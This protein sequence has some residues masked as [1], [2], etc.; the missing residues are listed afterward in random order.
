MKLKQREKDMISYTSKENFSKFFKIVSNKK[1]KILFKIIKITIV[2]LIGI[3]IGLLISKFFGTLDNPSRTL[4]NFLQI[5]GLREKKFVVDGILAE[6]IKIPFNWLRSQFSRP[7]KLYIDIGFEEYQKIAYKRE[8]AL[9]QGALLTSPEDYVPATITHNGKKYDIKLRLKGDNLDHLDT[10]KWSFRINFKKDESLFGMKVFSIQHPKT[11]IYINE[12]VYQLM[13]KREGVISLR[14]DFVDVFINGKYKGIYFL[15]EHFTNELIT[16]NNLREGLIVKFNE[17]LVWEE[18]V[19]RDK[20]LSNPFDDLFQTSI[21]ETFDDDKVLADPIKRAQFE[22]A[23]NLLESFRREELKTSE[24]FDSEKLAK[25][26]A[27]TTLLNCEHGS[28]VQNMRFYYN[29]FTS[30]LEPISFD[31]YCNP[32]NSEA[33]ILSYLP[34]CLVEEK[35]PTNCHL[36]NKNFLETTFSDEIFLKKY[37]QELEKISQEDYLDNLFEEIDLEIENYIKKLHKNYPYAHFSKKPIYQNQEQINQMLNPI[38]GMNAYIQE[39][40]SLENK[41][42]L[43]VGSISPFPLEVVS[44]EINETLVSLH[45]NTILQPWQ[46]ENPINYTLVEFNIPLEFEWKDE[47]SKNLKLNYRILGSSNT[48]NTTIVPW[49]NLKENFIEKDFIRQKANFSSFEMFSVSEKAK[50]ISIKKGYWK[51]EESIIIPKGFYVFAGEGTTI[52]LNNGA[53]ILSYSPINFKGTEK[54]PIKILSSDGTGQG[55]SVFE[56]KDS[57]LFEYVDF[58]NLTNPAKEGWILTGAINLYKSDFIFKNV[59]IKRM[60]SEDSLNVVSS[61]YT[62]QNSIFEECLSDCVDDDFGGGII[63]FTSFKNCGNDC[64]DVSGTHVDINNIKILNAGDKGVSSG[65]NASVNIEDSEIENG[66]IGVASKD[67]SKVFLENMHISNMEYGLTIYEKKSEFG[68]ASINTK[69]VIFS[70]VKKD[71]LVEKGSFLSINGSI[72]LGTETKVYE[73]L[74]GE[75]QLEDG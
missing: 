51:I 25:Y 53:M 19:K 74:Y 40:V 3:L 4:L 16:N 63:K 66:F 36:N 70:N 65:E 43:S 6:N 29:P 13:I 31:G 47:Y 44:L 2:L 9:E 45:K 27:I 11:R 10:K 23:K 50:S 54:N 39:N 32:T 61:R 5:G 64:I 48:L 18:H 35:N 37:I 41:I 71:Y 57:S 42:I 69:N 58:D 34:A 14:Y 33:V 12:V 30:L 62:I 1:T 52:D 7:E 26:F 68:P 56:S 72:I 60:K 38:Q 15:E 46:K 67:L 55:L 28:E 75:N 20:L 49:P 73:V 24:I 17:N 8:Q 21:I 22:K 59:Q